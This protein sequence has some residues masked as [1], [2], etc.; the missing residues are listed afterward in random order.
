[1]NNK[2]SN[3]SNVGTVAR[4]SYVPCSYRRTS[5]TENLLFDAL[6]ITS[7]ADLQDD[8]DIDNNG[9]DLQDILGIRDSMTLATCKR[10]EKEGNCEEEK[11][12]DEASLPP[13]KRSKTE[14]TRRN[15]SGARRGHQVRRNSKTT[16]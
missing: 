7:L 5:I 14:C 11:E 9:N 12:E 8:D 4:R 16:K 1:M 3:P 10:T 6:E 2:T 15:R 13:S